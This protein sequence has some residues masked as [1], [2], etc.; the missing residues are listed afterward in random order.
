MKRIF[1][2]FLLSITL[3]LDATDL[4]LGCQ[5]VNAEKYELCWESPKNTAIGA[6]HLFAADDWEA[7]LPLE[8]AAHFMLTPGASNTLIAQTDKSSIELQTDK[9]YLRIVAESNG[10]RFS[11][12]APLL[13]MRKCNAKSLPLGNYATRDLSAK[14]VSFDKI[15]AE[16]SPYL[17]PEGHP[18]KVHLDAIFSKSGVLASIESM[19]EAGFNI[20]IYRQGRGLIVAS[21]P[22]LDNFLIKTYLD[23]VKH[24]EWTRWVRRAK[25]RERMQK[26]LDDHPQYAPYLKAPKKWIYKIPECGMGS[27]TEESVPREYILLVENMDLVDKTTNEMMYKTVITYEALDGLYLIIDKTGFSDGHIGNLPFSADQ[28]IAFI[29]TEYTNTWPVHFDWLTKWFAPRKKRYWNRLIE[30]KGPK[31]ALQ[32]MTLLIGSERELTLD[33]L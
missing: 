32:E 1:S 15:K 33:P 31:V 8:P 18:I 16:V 11:D 25:G 30:N 17:L 6:Y 2:I 5:T 9:R 20:I 13:Q 19:E 3:N 26:F 14:A 4:L 29:D 27:A 24:V 7:L 21:H 22:L 28:R 23:T 12:I 10:E